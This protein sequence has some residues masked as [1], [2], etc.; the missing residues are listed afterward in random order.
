M[1]KMRIIGLI[2]GA[3]VI[4]AAIL[5]GLGFNLAPPAEGAGTANIGFGDLQHYELQ[6]ANAGSSAFTGFGDL[7]RYEQKLAHTSSSSFTGFGD[8]QSYEQKLA[9]SAFAA[10]SGSLSSVPVRDLRHP[11]WKLALA[12]PSV[13][14]NSPLY[15]GFGNAQRYERALAVRTDP[16]YTGFGDLQRYELEL[17]RPS[18]PAFTGFGDLQRY[19]TQLMLLAS[20]KGAGLSSSSTGM[21]ELQRLERQ[22]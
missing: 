4:V 10:P 17:A 18:G 22:P 7:Q 3:L 19:E 2:G 13:Q 8:L 12:Y 6:Q 15:T 1:N 5:I 11:E 21:G 20:A 9:L 16:A 14:A